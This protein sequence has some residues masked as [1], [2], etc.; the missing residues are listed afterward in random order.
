[1][2]AIQS[3]AAGGPELCVPFEGRNF[4]RNC[5]VMKQLPTAKLKGHHLAKNT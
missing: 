2:I 4:T 1:M 5:S 3:S